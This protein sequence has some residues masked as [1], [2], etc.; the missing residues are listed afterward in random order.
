MG[1]TL[2]HTPEML[3]GLREV[4]VVRSEPAAQRLG[5]AAERLAVARVEPAR[6]GSFFGGSDHAPRTRRV[7]GNGVDGV[8][9]LPPPLANTSATDILVVSRRVPMLCG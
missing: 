8:E 4:E 6:G 1:F 3:G 2:T 9:A 7:E 5:V